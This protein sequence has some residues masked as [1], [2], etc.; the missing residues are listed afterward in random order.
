MAR[1]LWR[2]LRESS[3]FGFQQQD[4]F[5]G[6]RRSG[7]CAACLCL[8]MIWPSTSILYDLQFLETC[9]ITLNTWCDVLA[10]CIA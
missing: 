1:L 10:S 9:A 2:V 7:A 8:C 5:Q 4:T 3:G 6:S